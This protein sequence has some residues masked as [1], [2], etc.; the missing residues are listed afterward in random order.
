MWQLVQGGASCHGAVIPVR[1]RLSIKHG[2]A[3]STVSAQ[4]VDHI[5][6][7]RFY[8]SVYQSAHKHR[9][10][11]CNEDALPGISMKPEPA[12]ATQAIAD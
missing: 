6:Y 10:I 3:W 5:H 1:R 2:L 11:I 9:V 8:Q 4:R 7:K 12:E